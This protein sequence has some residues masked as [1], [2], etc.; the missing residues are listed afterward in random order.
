MKKLFTLLALLVITVAGAQETSKPDY[1]AIQKNIKDKTSPY[2]YNTLMERFTK[3]DTTMT[4]TE[5]R[6]LY[7]GFAFMPLKMNEMTIRNIEQ[8]LKAALNRPN[9]TSADMEDV[10]T[11]AGQLLQAFPFSITLKEYRAY[12]LKQLGRYDEAMAEK[13]Q[14]EMIADAILSS[15]DGTTLQSAI[16]VIDAGNEYE[17]TSL[18]GF[19]TLDTEYLIN[20]KYDYITLNKNAYNLPGLYF[21]ASV[22]PKSV[23]RETAGL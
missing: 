23:S 3:A 7:Y 1:T 12:C 19:E 20:N 8:Q 14:T 13:A 6:H 2:Y 4:L 10:V 22:T 9:P 18:M 5:R 15:G 17:I 11:Y 16:H 21:D